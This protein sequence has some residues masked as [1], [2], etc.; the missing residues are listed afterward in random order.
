MNKYLMLPCRSSPKSVNSSGGRPVCNTNFNILATTLFAYILS[1]LLSNQNWTVHLIIH[2]YICFPTNWKPQFCRAIFLTFKILKL[3]LNS[4]RVSEQYLMCSCD[5]FSIYELFQL[6]TTDILQFYTWTKFEQWNPPWTLA[7][8]GTSP[9]TWTI[10][11][12][13]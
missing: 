6:Q 12:G 11:S 7:P 3:Y 8:V 10:I 13:V 9:Y 4:D 1:L 5:T 2:Q